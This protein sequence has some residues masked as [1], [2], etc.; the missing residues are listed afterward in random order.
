MSS[1]SGL[2]NSAS[3]ALRLLG[4]LSPAGPAEFS[5]GVPLHLPVLLTSLRLTSLVTRMRRDL[6]GPGG[7]LL[8]WEESGPEKA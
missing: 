1:G 2:D 4:R 3:L 5:V 6:R 7:L 8:P